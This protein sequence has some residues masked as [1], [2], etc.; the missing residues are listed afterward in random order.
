MAVTGFGMLTGHWQ[1]TITKEEYL[2]HYKYMNSY[3]HPTGS[4][5]VKEFNEQANSK[6]MD[7]S[8]KVKKPP[9]GN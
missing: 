7:K 5:A 8:E 2:T 9:V 1:N 4:E 6:A 3:G